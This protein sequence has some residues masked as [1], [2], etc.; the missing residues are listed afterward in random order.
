MTVSSIVN[1]NGP[2][3]GNGVATEFAWTFKVLDADTLKV[4]QTV[5]GVETEVTTGIT[6]SGVPGTS[7]NVTFD[8]AP[9]SGVL[10]T[11]IRESDQ[12]QETDYSAQARV[13]PTQVEDDLDRSA[14]ATQD[15]NEAI[16]RA[17][18]MLKSSTVSNPTLPD[19]SAGLTIMGDATGE[20][21]ID[22]P[23]SNEIANAQSYAEAAAASAAEAAAIAGARPEAYGADT[24][25]ADNTTALNAWLAA[26]AA[27]T[28]LGGSGVFDFQGVLDTGVCDQLDIDAVNLCLNY[29]GAGTTGTKVQI[30]DSS[31]ESR[32]VTIRGVRFTSDTTMTDG[33]FV[34]AE[35]LMRSKFDRVW[36]DG[37]DTLDGAGG[38]QNPYRGVWVKD[39]GFFTWE[40]YLI[41]AQQE[42][43]RLS[44]S[45]G[46]GQAEYRFLGGRI[47]NPTI[48][49]HGGGGVGG[50]Y[51]EGDFSL[52]GEDIR[53]DRTVSDENNREYFFNNF[54]IFD[55]S[56]AGG[57]CINIQDT[58]SPN[59]FRVHCDGTWIA[60][61][62]NHGVFIAAGSNV[63][64][65]MTGGRF[66]NMGQVHAGTGHG[67]T[68][69]ST[70]ATILLSA[71]FFDTNVGT[72]LNFTAAPAKYEAQGLTFRNNG[73]DWNDNGR[74][75]TFFRGN[76]LY[77]KNNP[78]AFGAVGDYTTDDTTAMQAWADAFATDGPRRFNDAGGVYRMTNRWS[79]PAGIIIDGPGGAAIQPYPL[80]DDEKAKL[81]PGFKD[82]LNGANVIFDGS[83]AASAVVTQRNDGRTNLNPCVLYSAQVS[84]DIGGF[85]IIQDMDV[86][87]AGGSTTSGIT[88]LTTTGNVTFVS[89]E[90]VVQDSSAARGRVV[91]DVTAGTSVQVVSVSGTFNE[92]NEIVGTTSGRPGGGA[93]AVTTV[94]DRTD[95]VSTGYDCGIVNR[96]YGS[97]FHDIT[98]YGY[99]HQGGYVNLT[100]FDDGLADPDYIKINDCNITSGCVILGAQA[101]YVL[102]TTG[103]VSVVAG[104]QLTQSTTGAQA[105]V[106]SSVTNDTTIKVALGNGTDFET[107]GGYTLTGST[108]GALG[109][110]SVLTDVDKS[111]G[112]NTGLKALGSNFYGTDHHQRD[113]TM[114]YHPGNDNIVSSLVISGDTT[115]TNQGIRGHSFIGCAF[116]GYANDAMQFKNCQDI[117]VIGCSLEFS[118]RD[119]IAYM[120]ETGKIIGEADTGN[121][122]MNNCANTS[123]LG[124]AEF[125]EATGGNICFIHSG[126]N[127][128]VTFGKGGAGVANGGAFLQLFGT[129]AGDPVVQ[130]CRDISSQNNDWT[131]R[132]DVSNGD[133]WELRYDGTSVFGL[134][135]DGAVRNSVNAQG[136]TLEI[137]SN[138]ITVP[139]VI[140]TF[141]VD[142]AGGATPDGTN[143][144][145]DNILGGIDGQEITLYPQS[146]NRDI[147]FTDTAGGSGEIRMSTAGTSDFTLASSRDL[148]RLRYRAAIGEWLLVSR[149]NNAP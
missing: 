14:M 95:N 91:F 120:D 99:M 52:C 87:D 102:E 18:K 130:W 145:V 85:S 109:A 2:Y 108:S 56:K 29:T 21:W 148:I 11:L 144:R 28:K 61:S 89:G 44:G 12:L 58:T 93:G 26:G 9:A 47:I 57:T 83:P 80:L 32:A 113:A 10:I 138:T 128:G 39:C 67:L 49:F 1:R 141:T 5:D 24:A 137:S 7:G 82:T 31:A 75:G 23:T 60:S 74:P 142:T 98:V 34:V 27:G 135:T 101:A 129:D 40:D 78:E 126:G 117:G 33:D 94:T 51:V 105:T 127:D 116:R 119:N 72:G 118:T 134:E 84:C 131:A 62:D 100:V 20:N 123:G 104:E 77:S 106:T 37:M 25:A 143:N 53:I 16:G 140:G 70:A 17:P 73:T 54:T 111:D 71:V 149:Q 69:E 8:T 90:E 22:G 15:L 30:G 6:K 35:R 97:R 45:T 55:E 107:A 59:S 110:N 124:L 122:T 43:V 114:V 136:T 13:L 133:I 132:C 48:G 88:T 112:G 46:K 50:V 103:N 66:Y 64:F 79:L 3:T 92:T 81:R 38:N 42:G 86:L 139:N 36:V 125:A 96:S 65:H 115:G 147:I 41:S 4:Y 76:V 146:T 68:N 63:T 121:L 19:P